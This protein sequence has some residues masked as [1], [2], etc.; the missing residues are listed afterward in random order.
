MAELLPNNSLASAARSYSSSTGH[1]VVECWVVD[2][3]HHQPPVPQQPAQKASEAKK[4]NL[5][6]VMNQETREARGVVEQSYLLP[7]D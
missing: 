7:K 1:M 4:K 3:S 5:K 2:G 6:L